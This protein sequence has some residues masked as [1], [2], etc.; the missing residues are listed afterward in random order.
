MVTSEILFL[1]LSSGQQYLSNDIIKV[2]VKNCLFKNRNLSVEKKHPEQKFSVT[3][4]ENGIKRSRIDGY[5]CKQLF[6]A[7]TKQSVSNVVEEC[8]KKTNLSSNWH[9]IWGIQASES[10]TWLAKGRKLAWFSKPRAESM[11]IALARYKILQKQCFSSNRWIT[12]FKRLMLLNQSC[13]LSVVEVY[14]LR[15][16]R[17]TWTKEGLLL[18]YLSF[19]N[20]KFVFIYG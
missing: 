2:S 10:I 14:S 6:D 16:K 4:F 13:R 19:N 8:A 18:T 15:T 20:P 7:S 11:R 1:K 5:D 3:F 17:Y 9:L 12:S